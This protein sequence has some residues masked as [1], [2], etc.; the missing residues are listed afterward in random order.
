MKNW[1]QTMKRREF[2]LNRRLFD[3]WNTFVLGGI[4]S[5]SR[6]VLGEKGEGEVVEIKKDCWKLI[7]YY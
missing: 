2:D 5:G 1:Y 3:G 4:D 6:G 7:V